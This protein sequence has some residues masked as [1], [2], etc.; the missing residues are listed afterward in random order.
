MKTEDSER[1][2]VL[3]DFLKEIGFIDWATRQGSDLLFPNIM[4]LKDPARVARPTCSGCSEGL[5][6]SARLGRK[7][8]TGAR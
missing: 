8:A 6:S 2:F 1:Y 3:H 7:A 5:G 4:K